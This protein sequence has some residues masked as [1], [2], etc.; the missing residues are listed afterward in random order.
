M[1]EIATNVDTI[2]KLKIGKTGIDLWQIIA[3]VFFIGVFFI[4]FNAYDGP[5]FLGEMQNEAA[6]IFFFIAFVL[7]C[8]AAIVNKKLYIPYN[9][10]IFQLVVLF[11]IWLIIATLLNSSNIAGYYF[12]KTSGAERFLRQYI[13]LFIS[14][15]M[16]FI[17]YYNIFRRYTNERLFFKLRKV[18]LYSL[19]IVSIYGFLEI[20]VVKFKI[21]QVYYLLGLFEYFPFTKVY[22]DFNLNR[23]SSVTFEPP[24]LATY[25]FTI[26]GWM[27]S[28]IITEKG[29]K[30]YIP[31]IAVVLL[32]FFSESRAGMFVMLVLVFIFFL[33]LVVN[34]RFHQTFIKIVLVG[35]VG[36]TIVS[37]VKGKKL[38]EFVIDKTTSFSVDKGQHSISN[39]SRFGLQYAM[40]K[41]FQEFPISGVGF[42][43][44]VYEAKKY[45]PIWS[46]RN[47][48]EF[49]FKYLNKDD[50]RFPP[51][52][53]VYLRLLAESG[54]IGFLIFTVLLFLIIY[55]CVVLFR[56]NTK[57]NL[58]IGVILISM[59]GFYLNWLKAD[60]FRVF[61]F[62]MNL[63]FLIK[64]M[65]N[66][67]FIY[68]KKRNRKILKYDLKKQFGK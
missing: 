35:M 39:K 40:F 58:I 25:L 8:I 34:R 45:Y 42:G 17:T 7:I 59:I 23:I 5:D 19:V 26:A 46:T 16:F 49:Q 1:E 2:K 6:V 68:R 41:T 63:A 12:K 31:A 29:F 57:D 33:L 4:P 37:V 9:N 65:N 61:G 20:L 13:S 38:V 32:A 28:Y 24:A 22:L 15:G 47:N 50:P 51:G 21:F 3:A 67:K 18:L 55:T 11:F 43:Q 14:G 27:F 56:R 64:I 60:T 53:N 54:I 44:Q 30:K 10:L 36:I 52:Y 62:W 66:T 48:W